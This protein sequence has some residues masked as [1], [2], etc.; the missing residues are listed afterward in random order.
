MVLKSLNFDLLK[1]SNLDEIVLMFHNQVIFTALILNVEHEEEGKVD[2]RF[3]LVAMVEK[4][5][6]TKV[7]CFIA[8]LSVWVYCLTQ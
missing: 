2:L 6:R 3:R 5:V 4:W 7:Q 8:F 1:P